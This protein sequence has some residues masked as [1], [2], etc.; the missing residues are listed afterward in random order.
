MKIINATPA[1]LR[2]GSWG[3][4]VETSVSVGDLLTIT[5]RSCKRWGARVTRIVWTG[6]NVSLCETQSLDRPNS[7]SSGR[8]CANCE[9]YSSRL[10]LRYDSSGLSGHCCPSCAREDSFALSFG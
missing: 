6:E 5:T 8:R 9:R 1:K 4:R 3:A 10:T 2:N 7:S